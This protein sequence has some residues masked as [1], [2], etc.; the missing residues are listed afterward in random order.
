MTRQQEPAEFDFD[1]WARLAREAPEA[2]E[3]AR[4]AAVRAV[5]DSAPEHLRRRLEG[6][7]WQLDRV[8]EQ[9]GS[10]LGACLRMSKLMWESVLG[11]SGLVSHLEQLGRMEMPATP[12]ASATVIRFPVPGRDCP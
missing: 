8:R 12:P 10:P 6:L 7:Q 1:A 9:A 11:D 5:I 2:F 3:A 4:L